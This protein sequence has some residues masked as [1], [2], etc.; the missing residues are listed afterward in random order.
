[1]WNK[2]GRENEEDPRILARATVEMELP[3]LGRGA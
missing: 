1:M 3:Y 2:S